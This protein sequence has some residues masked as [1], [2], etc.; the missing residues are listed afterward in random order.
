ME[1][2]EAYALGRTTKYIWAQTENGKPVYRDKAEV[3]EVCDGTTI[4]KGMKTF[5]ASRFPDTKFQVHLNYFKLGKDRSFYFPVSDE[6]KRAG[7]ELW[8]QENGMVSKFFAFTP[9]SEP[10]KRR[11]VA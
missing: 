3:F 7:A 10:A 5:H 8:K 11:R 4:S 9:S 6:S 2:F 1:T